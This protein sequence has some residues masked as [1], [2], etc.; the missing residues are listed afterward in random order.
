MNNFTGLSLVP[1]RENSGPLPNMLIISLQAPL[2]NE[3]KRL[4]QVKYSIHWLK[5]IQGAGP[6]K[7]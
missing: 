4:S 3:T 1:V 6:K 7:H 5:F 2:L